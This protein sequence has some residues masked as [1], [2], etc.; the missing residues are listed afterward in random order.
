MKPLLSD[1]YSF[2]VNE[3]DLEA[4]EAIKKYNNDFFTDFHNYL[5]SMFQP[6]HVARV[7]VRAVLLCLVGSKYSV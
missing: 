6:D 5:K 4:V 3:E 7:Y 1:I 2:I